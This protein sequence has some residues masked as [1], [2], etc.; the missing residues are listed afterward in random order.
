M[1]YTIAGF[2]VI[3]SG[4]S[5][6]LY[7]TDPRTLSDSW[8]R[9]TAD[10]FPVIFAHVST[11]ARLTALAKLNL[12]LSYTVDGQPIQ[13]QFALTADAPDISLGVPRVASGASLV[14]TA[15]PNDGSAG[16]TLPPISPGRITLDL[17]SFREYG[18][19]VVSIA[20]VFNGTS[21]PLFLDLLRED[22]P[23]DTADAPGKVVLTTDQPSATWGYVAASPFHAGYRY[24]RSGSSEVAPGPW[25]PVVS[26]FTPLTLNADGTVL[27]AM[28]SAS[29]PASAQAVA[30]H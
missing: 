11:V 8:V 14:I 1:S 10:D 25:S 18:P 6:R 22:Q 4:Q 13:Q 27:V 23:L 12:A 30:G 2:A 24:R 3:V 26:P 9:L 28:N 20:G 19:H 16:L 21:N 7:Q 17:T 29:Q 5:E 15:V